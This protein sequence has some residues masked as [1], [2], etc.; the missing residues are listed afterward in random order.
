MKVL[1]VAPAWVG[2]MVMAQALFRRLA[3]GTARAEVHVTA[4]PVTLA[5]AERMPE[6]AGRHA[7]AVG[8]GQAGLGAR[9]TLAKRLKAERFDLAI[10]LPRSLKA[11]LAPMLAG[12]PRRRGYRGEFRYGLLNEIVPDAAGEI[13]TVDD[14]L[15]LAEDVAPMRE[16]ERPRL[17]ADVS[18]GRAVAIRLGMPAGAPFVA[19]APG[20]EYGPAK[21][22]PAEKFAALA[23]ALHAKGRACVVIGSAKETPLAAEIA[24]RAG[25]P[26]ADATGRTTIPEVIDLIAAAS[27]VVTND[28]GLMHVAAALDRPLAAVFGSSSAARTPPLSPLA[29]VI[30]RDDLP[31]RPCFKRECPLGHTA[32]LNGIEAERV[33]AALGV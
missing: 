17:F 33:I 22:W 1:V 15:A 12:I 8:H 28:S 7:L 24:A 23:K 16:D 25:V 31:C 13:R 5:V 18:A 10:V 4:P 21:R 3:R 20:A 32:C 30:E 9:W 11:A 19:L 26:V 2:D 29:R 14:F 27:A 6:V